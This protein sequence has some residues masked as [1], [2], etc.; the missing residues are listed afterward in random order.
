M[1]KTFGVDGKNFHL[2]VKQLPVYKG[3][4]FLDVRIFCDQEPW[5][6]L[7][8]VDENFYKVEGYDPSKHFGLKAWSENE[9]IAVWLLN[10]GFFEVLF[11]DKLPGNTPLKLY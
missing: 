1:F 11:N 5:W 9:T 8:Y 6:T 3:K 2:E 7:S 10:Q 4:T